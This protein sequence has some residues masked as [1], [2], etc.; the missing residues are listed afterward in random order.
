M[1]PT[2]CALLRSFV[3][4]RISLV[5]PGLTERPVSSV[6]E[7]LEYMKEVPTRYFTWLD[8]AGA[9]ESHRDGHGARCLELN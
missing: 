8:G 1:A 4:R 6:D 5:R 3:G 7:V 2:R 9:G